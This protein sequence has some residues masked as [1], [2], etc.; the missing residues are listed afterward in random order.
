MTTFRT[1]SLAIG[2]GALMMAAMPAV[3]MAQPYDNG[4]QGYDQRA[5]DQ[6]RHDYDA[7]YGSGSYDRY[8]SNRDARH[9]CHV[10]KKDNEAVGGILGGVAGA[11]IGSNVARGG[12]REGGAIIGGVAG[13][14][15]GSQIAKSQ[16]DC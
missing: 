15:A 6:Q 9:D 12:G 7:Q 4:P 11:V 3:V 14:A 5:Y 1:Q 16:T 10:A 2:L 13:A 8:M